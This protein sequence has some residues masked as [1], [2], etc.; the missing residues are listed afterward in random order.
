MINIASNGHFLTHMPHHVH[1]SSEI[2]VFIFV[3][4]DVFSTP[5]HSLPIPTTGQYFLHY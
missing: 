4:V 2:F 1:N 3:I 5:M